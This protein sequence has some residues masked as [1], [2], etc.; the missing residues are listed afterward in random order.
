MSDL[1]PGA[2]PCA[3]FFPMGLGAAEGCIL[4]FLLSQ[5]KQGFFYIH[6]LHMWKWKKGKTLTM[7]LENVQL[8]V[9]LALQRREDM[10]I[11]YVQGAKAAGAGVSER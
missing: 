8:S 6:N 10:H 4:L 7:Q 5:S 1:C 3:G 2:L 9:A 11:L